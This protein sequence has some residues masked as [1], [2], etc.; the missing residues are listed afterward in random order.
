[1]GILRVSPALPYSSPPP[2]PPVAPVIQTSPIFVYRFFPD[3][4][5]TAYYDVRTPVTSVSIENAQV[6]PEPFEL[7]IKCSEYL[8]PWSPY[9]HSTPTLCPHL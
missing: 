7:D 2:Y 6:L 3:V 4:T 5:I 9:P 1:M 8:S